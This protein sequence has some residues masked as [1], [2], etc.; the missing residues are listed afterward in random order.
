MQFVCLLW[1]H[2]CGPGMVQMKDIQEVAERIV[3]EFKPDRII[4][5]GS[6]ARGAAGVDS[7]VD[8]LVILPFEGMGSGSCWR[9]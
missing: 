1:R 6:Y 3:R 8:L 4:L 7:G 2:G 5:F 9:S